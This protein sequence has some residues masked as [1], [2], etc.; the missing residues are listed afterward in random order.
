MLDISKTVLA[1]LSVNYMLTGKGFQ[2]VMVNFGA[3]CHSATHMTFPCQDVALLLHFVRLSLE[4]LLASFCSQDGLGLNLGMK[5][6]KMVKV[7]QTVC[8]ITS[9]QH[10]QKDCKLEFIF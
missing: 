9:V 4:V 5:M 8:I 3:V 6:C 10:T 1:R 2:N 7:P